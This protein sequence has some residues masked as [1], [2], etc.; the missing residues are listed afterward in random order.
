M[1][2]RL[3]H[4]FNKEHNPTQLAAELRAAGIDGYV[5]D[6]GANKFWINAPEATTAAAV[7]AVVDAHVPAFSTDLQAALDAKQDAITPGENIAAP[8]GAATDQDDESR[9][10][11]ASI[12]ALLA[13][14]GLMAEAEE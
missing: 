4:S 1:P 5:T 9:A 10:A 14:K 12:L 13:E 2:A 7:A 11:I 8:S 3:L 6:Q